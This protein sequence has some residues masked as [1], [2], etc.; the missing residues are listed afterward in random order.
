MDLVGARSISALRA[1]PDT[2]LKY[3][4]FWR[5]LGALFIDGFLVG[6]LS[7]LPM[8]VS[9]SVPAQMVHSIVVNLGWIF[10]EVGFHATWGKTIGKMVMGIGVVRTD[11]SAIGWPEAVLRSAVEMAFTALF[12]ASELVFLLTVDPATWPTLSMIQQ[13]ELREQSPIGR[14]NDW[15]L[16]LMVAWTFSEV[17]VML[18]NKRRR[19]LHDFIAG[20][21]VVRTR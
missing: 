13:G 9:I 2:P 19:A 11:G 8:I 4:G 21:I 7:L 6:P 18:T 15:A 16:Y 20:T 5:R 17:L 10:Y 14:F 3:A 12:V 1:P